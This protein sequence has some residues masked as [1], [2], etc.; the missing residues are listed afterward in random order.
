[1]GSSGGYA[2]PTPRFSD[3]DSE[4]DQ[5]TRAESIEQLTTLIQDTVGTTS[6][7]AAYGGELSSLREITGNLIVKTTPRN[8][9]A[10]AELIAQMQSNVEKMVSVEARFLLVKSKVLDEEIKKAGGDFIID[11]DK[12][13]AFLKA[14][15]DPATG[16]KKLGGTKMVMFNG[17]RTY[18]TA[19]NNASF[20]SDVEPVSGAGGGLDPTVSVLSSGAKLDIEATVTQGDKSIV[21][22]VRSDLIVGTASKSSE[23]PG[24]GASENPTLEQ[25]GSITGAVTPGADPKAPGSVTGNVK[26]QGEIKPG[27]KS[28]ATSASIDLPEQDGVIYRT[29]VAIPN[30]GAVILTGSSN[31]LKSLNTEDAEIVMILRAKSK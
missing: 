8:H 30:G 17:Q 4:G 3:S 7:W 31:M 10:I 22:T 12:L 19:A 9:K 5:I 29:S 20:L 2:G 25:T 16:N 13:D 6:E 18:L 1:G 23:I 11:P 21:M 27:R 14:V 26:G 28:A 15:S 24:G